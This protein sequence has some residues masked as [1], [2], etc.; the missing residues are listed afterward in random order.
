MSFSTELSGEAREK[1]RVAPCGSAHS[2]TTSRNSNDQWMIVHLQ[3]VTAMKTWQCP[4][5]MMWL[6]M[7]SLIK[8]VSY[9]MFTKR[10]AKLSWKFPITVNFFSCSPLMITNSLPSN[11][12]SY[13]WWFCVWMGWERVDMWSEFISSFYIWFPL[14]L[15][16]HHA[17]QSHISS[18]SPLSE[19]G[20]I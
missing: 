5:Q 7:K 6:Y 2:I 9:I 16:L 20:K 4:F 1:T 17:K 19:Y 11:E 3:S 15:A 18:Q 8:K 14:Q 10:T 13:S 12:P